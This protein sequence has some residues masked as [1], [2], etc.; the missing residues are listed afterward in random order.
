MDDSR[1]ICFAVDFEIIKGLVEFFCDREE[2]NFALEK[3]N[4]HFASR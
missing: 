3:I 1:D 4:Y 2:I